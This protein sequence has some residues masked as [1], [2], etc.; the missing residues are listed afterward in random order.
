MLL[1]MQS[2]QCVFSS[3]NIRTVDK[4][5]TFT[6]ICVCN[7]HSFALNIR[8]HTTLPR[9]WSSHETISK[10]LYLVL[11]WS[12]EFDSYGNL[13]YVIIS[14]TDYGIDL[15]KTAKSLVSCE[16]NKNLS[17]F[18]YI[19]IHCIISR[20]RDYRLNGTYITSVIVLLFWV[21]SYIQVLLFSPDCGFFFFIF[22][23]QVFV[24]VQT[25][26]VKM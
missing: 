26:L 6:S 8:S 14:R 5:Y 1:D 22:T 10:I 19:I 9:P 17:P 16:V 3:L 24:M 12:I 23:S 13:R 4:L 21:I 20:E 7:V 11:F 2:M 15:K 25:W 18:S